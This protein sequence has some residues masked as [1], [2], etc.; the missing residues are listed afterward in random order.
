[1]IG[2]QD[3]PKVFTLGQLAEHFGVTNHRIKY[4]VERYKI[5]PVTRVGI[6]RVWS[7]EQLDAIKGALDR[8]ARR[9]TRWEVTP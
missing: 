4:A 6:L 5:S 9:S 1:M 8:T 7:A 3:D 2:S